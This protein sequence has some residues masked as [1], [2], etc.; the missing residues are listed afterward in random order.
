MTRNRKKIY[1]DRR[2][3]L[4]KKDNNDKIKELANILKISE[5]KIINKIIEILNPLKFISEVKNE[6]KI[7]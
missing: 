1:S 3:F 6:N 5:N 2:H 4:L 7:D